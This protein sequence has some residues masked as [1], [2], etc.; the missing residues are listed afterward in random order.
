[1]NKNKI[2]ITLSILTIFTIVGLGCSKS[3]SDAEVALETKNEE[4]MKLEAGI[5]GEVNEKSVT[6]KASKMLKEYYKIDNINE[7]DFEIRKPTENAEISKEDIKKNEYWVEFE[8]DGRKSLIGTNYS[9]ANNDPNKLKEVLDKVNSELYDNKAEYKVVKTP[10]DE[11]LEVYNKNEHD[12]WLVKYEGEAIRVGF[13]VNA[14]T[15]KIDSVSN[16]DYSAKNSNIQFD[17]VKIDIKNEQERIEK[18]VKPFMESIGLSYNEYEISGYNKS[19][20]ANVILSN[21][22]DCKDKIIFTINHKTDKIICFGTDYIPNFF[23]ES[24]DDYVCIKKYKM[25]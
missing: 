23:Q 17:K 9:F 24:P 8:I 1:M 12:E 22:K 2:A 21:K 6:E 13:S 14:K 5:K 4:S 19:G 25:E 7:D 18:I 16:S 10:S 15:G 3:N 11:F 20:F